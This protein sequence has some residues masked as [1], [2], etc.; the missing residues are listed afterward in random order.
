MQGEGVYCSTS[1]KKCKI[2]ISTSKVEHWKMS[3]SAQLIHWKLL[4][5]R[6]WPT[7]KNA[8]E[9]VEE[10][11]RGVS[12]TVSSSNLVSTLALSKSFAVVT[13][14]DDTLHFHAPHSPQVIVREF[15]SLDDIMHGLWSARW[16]TIA[17]SASSYVDRKL[18]AMYISLSLW[19]IA[20]AK[21]IQ[22]GRCT[23]CNEWCLRLKE[24]CYLIQK[25]QCYLMICAPRLQSLASRLQ[26][27]AQGLHV[28]DQERLWLC[29]MNDTMSRVT[30]IR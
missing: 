5:S 27:D 4:C 1:F 26:S 10:C 24:W 3:F 19:D 11:G 25:C 30:W 8:Y 22:E 2:C 20:C 12:A 7:V 14:E 16:S 18:I 23:I 17:R 13:K 21:S 15:D 28:A 29:I 9:L 6:E